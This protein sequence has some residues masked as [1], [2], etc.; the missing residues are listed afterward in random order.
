MWQNNAIHNLL[1]NIAHAAVVIGV[2]VTVQ[3]LFLIA[4]L[5]VFG[6]GDWGTALAELLAGNL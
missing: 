5:A 4:I 2:A 3:V 1:N 6:A